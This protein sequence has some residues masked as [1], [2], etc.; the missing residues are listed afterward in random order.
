MCIHTGIDTRTDVRMDLCMGMHTGMC[1]HVNVWL[2][3]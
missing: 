3:Y 1:A 2:V